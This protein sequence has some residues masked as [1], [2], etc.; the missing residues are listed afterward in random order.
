MIGIKISEESAMQKPWYGK[1]NA[2]LILF[3]ALLPALTGAE[4]RIQVTATLGDGTGVTPR[5]GF[6][7]LELITF[8]VSDGYDE[9]FDAAVVYVDPDLL[10]IPEISIAYSGPDTFRIEWQRVPNALSYEVWGCSSPYGAYVLLG[11]TSEAHWDFA[12]PGEARHFFRVI[13][14]DQSSR[15][16]SPLGTRPGNINQ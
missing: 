12:V 2:I 8:T 4:G 3:F 9:A 13:A 14:T 15:V 11:S 7:G 5:D 1:L 6:S 16:K 10:A